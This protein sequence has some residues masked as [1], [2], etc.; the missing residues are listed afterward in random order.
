MAAGGPSDSSIAGTAAAP[1]GLDLPALYV[2]ADANAQR[3]QRR[4]QR[5]LGAQLIFALVCSSCGVFTS[6]T[7]ASW[8]GYVSAGA[9]L[10]I[11][12]LRMWQRS[13][14][15]DTAW[16]DARATAERVK[17]LTWRYVTRTNPFGPELADQAAN[18]LLLDRLRDAAGEAHTLSPGPGQQQITA[19][20]RALRTAEVTERADAYKRDRL[21]DQLRWYTSR[22]HSAH[23]AAER[24]EVAFFV[25][26]SATLLAGILLASAGINLVGLFAALASVVLSWAGG[27]SYAAL[28]RAYDRAALDVSLTSEGVKEIRLDH[29]LAEFVS[30]V[31]A[32]L[33][34]EHERWRMARQ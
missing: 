2:Q 23:A 1:G 21:A 32:M 17:S 27:R 8:P 29:E 22:A 30:T 20:M 5:L 28:S 24:W 26:A 11:V 12:L 33:T 4:Y 15:A 7:K 31:E 10:V 19:S 6:F 3:S 34:G 25:F 16:Y 9:S 18:S 14:H 13:T